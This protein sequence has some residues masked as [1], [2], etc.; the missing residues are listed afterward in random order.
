MLDRLDAASFASLVGQQ[1]TV[2]AADAVASWEVVQVK[3]LAAPSPRP[4]APFSVLLRDPGAKASWPQGL[5]RLTHP[6]HGDLD[7]F[8]VPLGPDGDGM[9]YEI[10]F[11]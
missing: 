2:A 6:E 4:V 10:T 1:V 5:Y 3:P 8:V 7:L 11:N 9:R